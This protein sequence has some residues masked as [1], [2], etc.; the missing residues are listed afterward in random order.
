[1]DAFEILGLDNGADDAA[2]RKAYLDAVKTHTPDVDPDN[3]KRCSRAYELI[4]DEDARLHYWLFNMDVDTHRPMDAVIDSF[5]V[6]RVR[7]P[8]P[9][10]DL[11]RMLRECKTKTK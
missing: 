3:F 5:H 1:M 2:I 7:K 11:M 9:F 10:N 6:S 8:L 4:K